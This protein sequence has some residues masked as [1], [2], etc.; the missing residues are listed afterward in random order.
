MILDF[1]SCLRKQGSAIVSRADLITL[2]AVSVRIRPY[3][4]KDAFPPYATIKPRTTH[5]QH[6]SAAQ[7][8]DSPILQAA[9]FRVE[10]DPELVPI[11]AGNVEELVTVGRGSERSLPTTTIVKAERGFA[12]VARCTMED[13]NSPIIRL[14]GLVLSSAYVG[15]KE[16]SNVK[17]SW[18]DSSSPELFGFHRDWDAELKRRS[19]TLR[20]PI[21]APA[22]ARCEQPVTILMLNASRVY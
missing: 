5:A 21:E 6:S 17:V 10:S 16:R 11:R 22:N 8:L 12:I 15:F 3:A 13:S 1:G 4:H 7:F 2:P 9:R 14:V 18:P 19:M 20:I